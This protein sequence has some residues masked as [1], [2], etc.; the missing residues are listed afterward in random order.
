M[1]QVISY[2]FDPTSENYEEHHLVWED[3]P[4]GKSVFWPVVGARLFVPVGSNDLEDI[5]AANSGA[6]RSYSHSGF[7]IGDYSEFFVSMPNEKYVGFKMGN[8]EAT[9]GQAKPLAAL[10]FDPYHR[11]KW[12]GPWES[13]LS[14]RIIGARAGEAELAFL[15]ASTLYEEKSGILPEL[16]SIDLSLILD[17]D[18][19]Q[20]DYEEGMVVPAPPIIMNLEALRFYHNDLDQVDDVA[21]CLYFYRTLEY[22]SFFTNAT[23]MSRL[24]HDPNISDAE[25]SRRMLDLVG[26]EEKGPI[27]K[28][29]AGLADNT[30]LAATVKDGLI[31]APLPNLF[32]EALYAFRNSI[33]HGKFSYGY[34]L[35]SGSV[36][37]K[38]PTVLKWK[39]VL[40]KLARLA[41]ARYGTK[42][43]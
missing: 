18:Y 8:I 24:R 7:S 43:V 41:L 14:L 15:N 22:F 39:V 9:F 5:T 23:E 6:F 20:P 10:I 3:A 26:R 34:S 38:D 13:I 21:A 36:L 17:Y 16:R 25:F 1:A 30:F 11:E 28:L 37:E 40:A 33:V 32:G 29:I 19:E 42:R 2:E 12:F 31:K 4:G 35:L 27:F